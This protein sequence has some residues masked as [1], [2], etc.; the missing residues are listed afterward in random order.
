[1]I[2]AIAGGTGFI[3]RHLVQF[4]RAKGYQVILISRSAK[5]AEAN[6]VQTVTWQQLQTNPELLE[7]VKAIINL[8]GESINQRW[9]RK[10]K[11]RILHSRIE[12]AEQIAE[13]VNRLSNKPDVVVNASGMSIYGSS[14]TDTYDENSPKRIVDFLSAVVE[15]WEHAADQI[16]DT[17]LV[18]IR[19]GLVLGNDGGAFPPMTLPY[20]L[21]FGGKVGSGR[22]WLSWIH[23]E[24]M[25]RLIDY[26]I[27]HPQISGP[28]NATAPHPVTSS[29]F[30]KALAHSLHRPNWFP[31]PAFM[32]KLIFG[33]MSA[34][35]LQGQRV[36]PHVLLEN[37]FTFRFRHLEEALTEL[38]AKK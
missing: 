16:Q 21:G 7:G 30:G 28:V 18:K 5:H 20:K 23:I 27:Q 8:A 11:E 14:E 3:G 6:D 13:L 35:L 22:Q 17:R 36:L 38:A 25:V 15:K 9:T 29:Q 19:I 1:M 32:L 2:I 33:E 4:F 34:L 12:A 26:C 31:V 10:A 37:G 24:D